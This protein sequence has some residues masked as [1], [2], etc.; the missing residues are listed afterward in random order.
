MT[1][2]SNSKK[3][4]LFKILSN[5][6]L[7]SL[8]GLS[9][10]IALII[11][12]DLTWNTFSFTCISILAIICFCSF[13]A[14]PWAKRSKISN[15]ATISKIFIYLCAILCCLLILSDIFIVNIVVTSKT[16]EQ[17][18]FQMN[19]IKWVLIFVIQFSISSSIVNT[20]L[21]YS[22]D[23]LP[24]QILSGISYI[25][26]DIY[27]TTIIIAVSISKEG[28]FSFNN[29]VMNYLFSKPMITLLVVACFIFAT[30]LI[31]FHALKRHSR[32]S[33]I[34]IDRRKVIEKEN[35]NTEEN[36]K[37]QSVIEDK[38]EK[39]N[40]MYEKKLITED[41]YNQKR[42]DILDKL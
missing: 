5:I 24:L 29:S 40:S 38:L 3:I 2:N 23:R 22:K 36:Q 4:N 37:E 26:F 20:Y 14:M 13:I 42:K 28:G 39:L 32:K 1:N 10:W 15:Y 16:L 18:I 35:P 34:N 12:T 8:L 41:E 9:I 31:W 30:T 6:S 21:Q 7:Y 33:G 17:S 19:F 27:L 25:V 11:T